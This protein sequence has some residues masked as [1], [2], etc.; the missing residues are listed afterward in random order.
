MSAS[1][2]DP[3]L[4]YDKDGKDSTI[5]IQ[6]RNVETASVTRGQMETICDAQPVHNPNES[7]KTY[8]RRW[9]GVAVIVLTN[10]AVTWAWLSFAMVTQFAQVHFSVGASAINWFSIVYC[11]TFIPFVFSSWILSRYGIKT[12][13]VIG[14]LG[15]IVGSWIRYAGVR[16][17]SYAGTMV[18][19]TILGLSQLFIVPLPPVYSQ[20]WFSPAHRTTPTALGTISPALG[21]MLGALCTPYMV[22]SPAALPNSILYLAIASTVISVVAFLVPSAPPT[23]ASLNECDPYSHITRKQHALA[24]LRSPEFYMIAVP[25][26]T[27]VGFFNASTS[28]ALLILMPYGF[29]Y[30]LGGLL[31]GLQAGIGITAGLLLAPIADRFQIHIPVLKISQTAMAICFIGYIWV[32]PSGNVAAVFAMSILIGICCT[33]GL[34]ITMEALAEILYPIPAEFTASIAWSVGNFLGAIFLF[35]MDALRAG[36]NANP[37]FNMQDALYCQAALGIVFILLPINL[38]GWFGRKDKVRYRRRHV[39]SSATGM[40]V[41]GDEGTRKE[42]IVEEIDVKGGSVKDV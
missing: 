39:Q 17:A 32:P 10:V 22:T 1:A 42:E 20:L 5:T 38:L 3:P 33:G 14:A 34:A 9:L 26:M 7:I 12:S 8:K 40:A 35:I 2:Q 19:Q 28:L 30:Q 16:T 41:S 21:S 29:P 25:F 23:P 24:I 37:P 6:G 18:G 31:T 4:P 15:I 27:E 11:F 13:L 36:P